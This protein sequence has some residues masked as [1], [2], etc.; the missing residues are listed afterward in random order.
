[1]SNLLDKQDHSH[2]HKLT[3]AG[4]FVTL[5]IIYGDIG[6][7]P[8]YVMKSIIGTKQI[9]ENY[10]VLGGISCVFW[11]LTF[12]TTIKYVIIT[13]KADNK[14]EGGIF[15]L[16]TLIKNK[17]NLWLIVPAMIG[18]ATLLADGIITPPISVASAVEGLKMI[19]PKIEPVP[20]VLVIIVL[21]FA[22]QQFG[23]AVVGKLFG[24]VMFIWFFMLAT[25]GLYQIAQHP[26]VLAAVN[27]YYAYNLLMKSPQGFVLLG[28]VFLC[29]TGAE[30]LYSDLGHCGR[31][32]IRVSWVF[33]KI[34]LILNYMGQGAWLI[35]KQGT[36]LS[37]N[38][39]FFTIMPD[40]FLLTGIIIATLAAII[41]SQ[42]LITGSFTLVSE[43][44]RLKLWPKVRLKYPSDVKG[45]LYVPS[46]NWLLL[47]GCIGV[48]LYFEES[49]KMEA[50]YGL[51]IT[52]T[53]L[54]TTLLLTYYLI[55]IKCPR[56]LIFTVILFYASIEVSFLIANLHKFMEGGI[57]TV[58]IGLVIISLMII[59]FRADIIKRKI[60]HS[61]DN[62][63]TLSGN[64]AFLE[65][66]SNDE[67]ITMMASHLVYLTSEAGD[68]IES[69]IIHSIFRKKPKR[70]DVYWF[71]H[72]EV[73]NEPHT[74]EYDV[75]II[76]AQ[77][78]IKIT[79]HLGFRVEQKISQYFRK[80]VEQI[81]TEGDVDIKSKYKSLQTHAGDFQFV[82]LKQFLSNDSPLNFID[83]FIMDAYF[84][85][86]SVTPSDQ[87]WF[88]L[89]ASTV[90]I[91]K[92]PMLF[93]KEKAA[94]IALVARSYKYGDGESKDVTKL[95]KPKE[96]NEINHNAS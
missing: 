38:N 78:I 64:E 37:D 90:L 76:A 73:T 70:A 54:M 77:D 60:N 57:V 59:M 53:M 8:L 13:L 24:P 20:I 79:F 36:R 67:S 72:V 93:N 62:F 88:G 7:S 15:S 61:K 5:G 6:T 65:K 50:A 40:W 46:V 85:I 95:K 94:K 42:A 69:A 3:I 28:A 87:S 71:I 52:I 80:V 11:T 68:K 43:A 83:N 2:S 92:T 34:C 44:I 17:K 4:L 84:L 41:A 21:L 81:V 86:K 91:E 47:A 1:V 45:Q 48:V 33:V 23:T 56:L 66:L 16:F 96:T 29:T 39:P 12:Q 18:G 19:Y 75:N 51:S 22:F 32:N 27:P 89:D 74:M 25:L 10:I 49:S 35:T 63:Q 55:K 26:E 9:I 14:G 58:F 82:I 30:A 31:K